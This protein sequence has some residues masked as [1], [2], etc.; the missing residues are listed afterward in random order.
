M[1]KKYMELVK[2]SHTIFSIP[3]ILIA[4]IVAADGWF[5]WKL[6]IL[7]LIAAVSARNFAMAYNRF[8]DRDIDAKNPRTANRPSVTG[9]VKEKE[10]ILF[11]VINAFIFIITAYLINSLAFKLSI[12]ILFVLAGYSHF[13]RFSEFA[14]L[15]LGIALG[16]APIAGAVAVTNSIPCWSVFLAFGVMFWV[17]GFD[18]LYSLQDMEFDKEHNLHSIPALVGERGALFISKMFHIFVVIFWALFAVYAHLGFFGWIAVIIGAAM[19][20]YEQML[21]NRDFKNIP[22]AFFNVN[23]FLGIIFLIF[24]ILDKV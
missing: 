12:P 17:A 15:V 16:L 20:Y 5:G 11:I 13:K 19:L 9:E 4:M 7:G 6:L 2:F 8:V 22:K 3:F 10:M 1:L 24:I 18:I 14:H 23:G 21:V